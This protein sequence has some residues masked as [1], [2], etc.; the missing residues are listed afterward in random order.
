MSVEP[1][2]PNL[3][4]LLEEVVLATAEDI[5]CAIPG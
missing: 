3:S 5:R 2:S 4:Q 1:G